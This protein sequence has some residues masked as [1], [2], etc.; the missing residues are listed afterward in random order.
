MRGEPALVGKP[1]PP[2]RPTYVP[3]TTNL[4]DAIWGDRPDRPNTAITD[5]PD[6]QH[7]YDAAQ[8]AQ[9]LQDKLKAMGSPGTVVSQLDEVAW[10][11]NCRAQDIPYNPVSF[12]CFAQATERGIALSQIS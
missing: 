5:L 4:V 7:G 8:K 12:G 6:D 9:D 11:F 1:P 3:I 2:L 10:L